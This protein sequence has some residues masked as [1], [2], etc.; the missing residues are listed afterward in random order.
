MK[1][2]IQNTDFN[3]AASYIVEKYSGGVIKNE[4]AYL[5][6]AFLENPC[7]DTATKIIEY[8]PDF[9]L[10]FKECRPGGIIDIQRN[11]KNNK[12]A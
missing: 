11:I 5:F 10:I 2:D 12:K 1:N 4:L 9:I 6:D 7:M 3:L 8:A